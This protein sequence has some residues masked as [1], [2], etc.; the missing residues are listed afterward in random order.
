MT[1]RVEPPG[2]EACGCCEGVGIRTPQAIENRPGLSAIAYRTGDYAAFRDSMLA[3]LSSSA[4]TPLGR[5]KTRETDDFTIALIDALA[6]AAD[7]I[8]FYQERI[9]NESY[10]RTAL[11]R[12][13]LQELA[14]LIGYRLRPGVAAETSLAF[15]LEPP[16]TAPPAASD[17]PGGFVTGVPAVVMLPAGL[18]VQSV[19]GPNETPQTFETM[20]P[21]EARPEWNAIK[22]LLTDTRPPH[23]GDTDLWIAGLRSN[24]K[25]GDGLVFVGD[26]FFANPTVG[27]GW[28]FRVVASVTL[29]PP[30][31]RTHVTWN[32]GL[33]SSTASPGPAVYV[34]R[35]RTAVFGHNAPQW[36]GLNLQFRTAYGIDE[37]RSDQWPSFT[38]SALPADPSGGYIDLDGVFANVM[39]GTLAVLTRGA[40]LRRLARFGG[41][42]TVQLYVV[43]STSEVSRAEFALSAKVTRLGLEG[44]DLDSGFAAFPRETTVYLQS[45]RLE[46]AAYPILDPMEDDRLPVAVAAD[47]LQPGRR[48]IV[49]GRRVDTGAIE[50]VD[51]TL[52]AV[53]SLSRGAQLTIDPPLPAPLQR[54][55]V[56][57]HANVALARHGETVAQILGSG[58]GSQSFQRFPL[59]RLPLTYRS[60][61]TDSGAATELTVRVGD[62]AWME[63]RSLF[64]AAPDDHVY[65][66]NVDEQGAPSVVFGDGRRGAR[67]PSGTNNVRATYRTGLGRAGNLGADR[68]TQLAARPLGLKTVSNPGPAEGGSDPE[69]ASQ[70]RRTM[71]LGTRTLARAVSLVD[72]EDFAMAFAGIA[73]AQA[74]VLHM[75]PGPA[76]AVTIAAQDGASISTASPLWRNLA[77]A[78]HGSGDPNVRVLLLPYRASSFRLGLK[79]KRDPAYERDAVIQALEQ[80]LRERFAFDA[81]SLG[82]PVFLSEVVAVA[83]EI[84]GVL[85]VDVDFLYGGTAPAAQTTPSLQTRLLASGMRVEGGVARPAELLTLD[86]SP[87]DRLQE[88]A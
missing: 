25:V 49:K 51:A 53:E 31:D 36:T 13:S 21:L 77:R 47:G 80:A 23:A 41:A 45:E 69:P 64:G 42:A 34:L 70:A 59:K 87:F 63:R 60:A 4:N 11:E 86:P 54:E 5:L 84:A 10:L 28:D 7:V 71:P 38:I 35:A 72:Y 67:L 14:K 55:S 16:K 1:A 68:L 46:L 37:A 83:H 44:P 78:F 12:V 9:A 26:E 58:N 76:V 39:P 33:A 48:L 40:L 88:M 24:V 20:E 15:A 85:A 43:S 29:D 17:N 62:V 18:K 19:P 75:P 6:C 81:R 74:A 66:V 56:V 27:T 3:R 73:K 2:T 8:T 65:T 52:V 30:N 32:G 79:V 82:Q 61:A 22:P 50:I 57:V